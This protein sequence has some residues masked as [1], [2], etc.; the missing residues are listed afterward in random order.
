MIHFVG[1]RG[2]EFSSAVRIWGSPDYV[3]W[4]HD[5]RLCHGGELHP[6]DT[7]VF[8]NGSEGRFTEWTFNDSN[9][10]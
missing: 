7:V 1:F 6:D 4:V 5:N 9:Y 2:D 3:H 8:A 10:F